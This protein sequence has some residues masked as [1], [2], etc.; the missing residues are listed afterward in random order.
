MARSFNLADLFEIVAAAV[1]GKLAIVS[2]DRRLTYRELDERA[3]RVAHHLTAQGVRPG[4]TV[5]LLAHNRA[6]WLEAQIGAFK[7]RAVPVNVNYRYTAG[8]LAYVIGDS[9][10]V[11]LVGER[12]LIARL[13]EARGKLSGLRHVLVVEDGSDD[14]VPDA[15]EYEA[16]LA[17]ASPENDFGERSPDDLYLLYT[18]GTTGMPKGVMWRHEDIFMSAMGGG[19]AMGDPV[20]TPETLAEKVLDGGL[21][22]LVCA[23]LMHGAGMWVAWLALTTGSTLILW[24]GRSFDAARVLALAAEERAVTLN[25]VGDAM[26]RPLIAELEAHPGRYDLSALLVIATGGAVTSPDVKARL[27]ELIPSLLMILDAFG[28]SETGASGQAVAPSADG[29]PRFVPR[30]D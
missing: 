28:G 26:A 19:N 7:L 11:A 22:T 16:A 6:E 15:V 1:P 20:P 23:P 18:G 3:N 29:Q 27:H 5:S 21:N 10:S 2:G 25:A 30:G 14:D 12:S 24:T 17:A 9:D 4:D 8:E 13:G